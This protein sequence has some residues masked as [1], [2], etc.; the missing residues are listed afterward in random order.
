MC[1]KEK[2]EQND[3]FIIDKIANKMRIAHTERKCVHIDRYESI[4]E[5]RERFVDC[6]RERDVQVKRVQLVSHENIQMSDAPDVFP[7]DGIRGMI[8]RG[9]V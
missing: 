6:F 5:L 1:F 9:R 3:D 8:S 4:C 7:E 2:K